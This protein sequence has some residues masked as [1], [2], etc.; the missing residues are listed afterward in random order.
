LTGGVSTLLEWDASIP[1][2]PVLHAEVLKARRQIA[3]RLETEPVT[4]TGDRI[5]AAGE[6]ARLPSATV[7]HPAAF[8]AAEVE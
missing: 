4:T 2:F 6:G 5:G 8:I 3:G 1:P 7:P